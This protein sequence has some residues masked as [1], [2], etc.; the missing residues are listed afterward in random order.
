[1]IVALLT[2]TALTL[3]VF[4][5][6]GLASRHY[7]LPCPSIISKMV[8]MENP[9]AKEVRSDF[10]I[11]HLK[12]QPGMAVADIGCGPGRV[13]IPLSK[14]YKSELHITAIDIQQEMLDKVKSKAGN[15]TNI[16]YQKIELGKSQLNR[17]QFDRIVMVCI[18]GEI[19]NQEAALKEVFKS[20]K[21][22]GILSI[23][24]TIFDPHYQRVKK[25]NLLAE[26][27]GLKKVAYFGKW[28]SYTVHFS[29]S[30]Y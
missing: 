17:N 7:V 11:K 16:T 24:E 28:W 6:W 13:T 18:M 15:A 26:K 3:L 30:E 9:W 14:V 25:L 1:M 22:N 2:F 10:I 21:P 23:S 29:K 19:P 27:V 4:I 8:E 12:L 5:F 20:L